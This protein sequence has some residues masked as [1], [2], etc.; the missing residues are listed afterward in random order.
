MH[1]WA[2]KYSKA[3]NN[4]DH[5][6]QWFATFLPSATTANDVNEERWSYSEKIQ[7][8]WGYFKLTKSA[9]ASLGLRRVNLFG[10]S[11]YWNQVR[12]PVA[13]GLTMEWSVRNEL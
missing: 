5:N 11:I 7:V 13:R 4:V 3:N 2:C 1:D 6:V 10:Y 8:A 9:L 12:G